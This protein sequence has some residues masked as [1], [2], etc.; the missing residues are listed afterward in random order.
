MSHT[1]TPD[2]LDVASSQLCICSDLYHEKLPV[3]VEQVI[4]PGLPYNSDVKM[5]RELG[6]P[7]TVGRLRQEIAAVSSTPAWAA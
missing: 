1:R 7:D 6:V 2:A 4:E 5:S 3:P